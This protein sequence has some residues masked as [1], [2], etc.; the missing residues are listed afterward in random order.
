MSPYYSQYL[1]IFLFVP[2][3]VSFFFLLADILWEDGD[4]GLDGI[5]L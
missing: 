4:K 5:S 3:Y 1:F 2:F